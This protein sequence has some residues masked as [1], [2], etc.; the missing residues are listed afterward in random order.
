MVLRRVAARLDLPESS[1]RRTG[2]KRT[3]F[4]LWTRY[5]RL[6]CRLSLK[7][8][9]CSSTVSDLV[10]ARTLS[11]CAFDLNVARS[12]F[13]P[14]AAPPTKAAL[15]FVGVARRD[16]RTCDRV[17]RRSALDEARERCIL[18]LQSCRLNEERAVTSRE[19]FHADHA[20]VTAGVQQRAALLREAS[21]RCSDLGSSVASKKGRSGEER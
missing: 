17:A 2:R 7:G 15:E 1:N 6:S 14:P 12:C 9:P 5:S 8:L 3:S 18:V 11:W 16:G 10:K 21:A 4:F 13:C 19:A 20:G